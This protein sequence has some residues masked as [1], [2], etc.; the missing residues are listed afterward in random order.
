[1]NKTSKN[2]NILYLTPHCNLKCDYCYEEKSRQEN[3]KD[4]SFEEVDVFL[5]DLV[6]REGDSQSIVI[7]Y[8]GEP[9]LRFDLI[10]YIIE[11]GTKL[12]KGTC[13]WHITTNGTLIETFFSELESLNE[14]CKKVGHFLNIQVSW[15]GRHS[16]RRVFRT[17]EVR[18]SNKIVENAIERLNNSSLS[19][20]ISYTLQKEN[21]PFVYEDIIFAFMKWKNIKKI[22]LSWFF[23]ELR[24][25]HPNIELVKE[26]MSHIFAMIYE[27]FNKPI[28]FGCCHACR[29]C[30]K[31][32][33]HE[34]LA[35]PGKG[36]KVRNMRKD[37][38]VLF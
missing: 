1:M 27:K 30:E 25:I 34:S 17:K 13:T 3:K 33:Q 22:H 10:K 9:F 32:F 20:E 12:K 8:G 36:I 28:C 6:K 26:K 23:D 35:V 15:D 24:E 2:L 19:W 11:T 37:E 18:R 21:F 4:L 7:I 16:F 31:I 5:E 38:L 14:L 29:R